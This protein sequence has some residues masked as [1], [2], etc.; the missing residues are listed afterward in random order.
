MTIGSA[1]QG[2]ATL[3]LEAI[4][5]AQIVDGVEHIVGSR[6]ALITALPD[7]VGAVLVLVVYVLPGGSLFMECR[8][9][10]VEGCIACAA[11]AVV[12]VVA[13]QLGQQEIAGLGVGV[14]QKLRDVVI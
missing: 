4:G 7:G 3:S 8:A 1:K 12:G 13:E 5:V 10:V 11:D 14:G 6:N 2:L 9:T